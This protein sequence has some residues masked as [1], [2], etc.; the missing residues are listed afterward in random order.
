MKNPRTIRRCSCTA[1]GRSGLR[2][3]THEQRGTRQV[4]KK[5]TSKKKNK[6]TLMANYDQ[7]WRNLLQ[8]FQRS[9]CIGV[10]VLAAKRKQYIC[11]VNF[12]YL[13]DQEKIFCIGKDLIWTVFFLWK[14]RICVI[15]SES[16]RMIF[17][18]EF[19][20]FKNPDCNLKFIWNNFLFCREISFRERN[21]KFSFYLFIF[22]FIL[23]IQFYLESFSY[24]EMI[25]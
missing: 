12:I 21:L 14:F 18:K 5:W 9:K 19:I 1:G 11:S 17:Y 10:F 16:I 25:N 24:N 3:E 20:N 7:L 15:V 6:K 23:W 13:I 4:S 2:R 8:A 22:F